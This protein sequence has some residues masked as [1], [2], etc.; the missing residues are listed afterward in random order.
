MVFCPTALIFLILHACFISAFQDISFTT[1]FLL[2][3]CRNCGGFLASQRRPPFK[4]I[5]NLSGKSHDLSPSGVR[6]V[7]N[8]RTLV[9]DENCKIRKTTQDDNWLVRAP[10]VW[11][12]RSAGNLLCYRKNESRGIW[13]AHTAVRKSTLVT[14]TGHSVGRGLFAMRDFAKGEMIGT[15]DGTI[16]GKAKDLDSSPWMAAYLEGAGAGAE[17]A[18]AARRAAAAPCS[19]CDPRRHDAARAANDRA[20]ATRAR[21]LAA[22]PPAR[23]GPGIPARNTPLTRRCDGGGGGGDRTRHGVRARGQLRRRRRGGG[24]CRVARA[25]TGARS[26]PPPPH[27]HHHTTPCAR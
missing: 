25:Q 22:A 8:V 14:A 1:N 12:A 17:S 23:N 2:A 7:S 20:S 3:K 9:W 10:K 6:D 13:E 26:R 16:L 4:D 27:H 5:L 19:C 18:A 15:Y 24:R 11:S 21:D